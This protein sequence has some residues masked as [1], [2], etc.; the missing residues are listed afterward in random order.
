MKKKNEN[1]M[2]LTQNQLLLWTGQQLNPD[3]P[4]YNM[5]MTY[6]IESAIS[7]PHFKLAFQK[8]VDKSDVLRSVFELEGEE[9]VQKYLPAIAYEL[10]IIDFS[11]ENNPRATFSDWSQ[12]RAKHQFD[13]SQCLF[14][15]VLIK[16]AENHYIWYLNQHHL[17]T[18]GW[19][20]SIIFSKVSDFYTRAIQE[21][22]TVV[23]EFPSYQK[24]ITYTQ[25]TKKS[26]KGKEIS[27][28]WEEK[29]KEFPQNQITPYHK[30]DIVL[31]TASERLLIKLGKERSE[32]IR[33]LANIKGIRTWTIDLTLYNIFLTVLYA[34]IYRITGQ[35]SIVIGSP[36]HNRTSK[37]FKDTI[38]FFVETF[39]LLVGIEEEESFISL[40][41][42]VQIESNSFIKNAQAGASTPE[43]NRCFNVFFNYINATN[44]NFNGTPVVTNWVHPGHHD[45]RHHIRL[46]VHDFDTTGEIQL[47]FDL[48][49][50]IFDAQKQEETTEHFL[51][52]LDAFIKNKD[53]NL[54]NVNLITESETLRIKQ[55][56]N[57]ITPYPKD[58]TLLSKFKTQVK[59]TPDEIALVFE[60]KTLTYKEFDQKSNQV[61]NFLLEREIK[62]NDI[63]AISIDR[64]LEMMIYIY[65]IIK[66]GA[67]YLPID[68]SIP[69]ERLSFILR[70]S[71]TKILF[72]DHNN[73]SKDLL[74]ITD[75]FKIAAINNKILSLNSNTPEVAITPD[76]LA[77]II[78][79]SGSTGEPKGVKC[80]HRGIC[81]RLNWM[82]EDY[83]ITKNDTLIQK[84]PIT[85]DVSL[86]ELFWPFQIGAKLIIESPNGH[87]DPEKLIQTIQDNKVTIIH[88]VPSMLNIFLET[89]N[90]KDCISLQRIFCSGEA[91]SAS[92]VARAFEQLNIELHNLYGPTEASVEVTSWHCKKDELS[93]SIPIGNP[94]ANTHIYILDKNLNP[95]PIGTPGELYIGGVQ[96]ANGYLNREN[97]SK[98]HFLKDPFS[99][100][101][102]GM[103]YKTGDLAR[104]RDD[105]AIQYVG[106]IDNQVKVRGLRIELGEIEKVIEKYT[107]ISQAIVIVD[108]Q[109]NLIA[110]YTGEKLNEDDIINVLENKLPLYMVPSYFMYLTHFELLSSGK[111]DRK[112]LPKYDIT[113][114][115]GNSNIAAAPET[116]IEEIILEVWKEVLEI[117]KIG[118]HENFI[119]VGGNSLLA[120]SI[121]SRLKSILELD[122]SITDMFNYPTISTYAQHVEHNIEQL[123]NEF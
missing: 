13:I 94:V 3:T 121:T 30:K 62:T 97:L 31:R 53:A 113:A 74:T 65:G 72:Y 78:Y 110:Y 122:I 85:F 98:K 99:E 55:W 37:N 34:Y 42:K 38:G 5:V 84:T 32:K 102:N 16:L 106:R 51:K 69:P 23:E 107:N 111:V 45:P 64:S 66:S 9:P 17:I 11:N 35:K 26:P 95:L 19:S 46:H 25:E 71:N 92:S 70:D 87:K 52:L 36:T 93:A 89:Q 44:T 109:E 4:L 82:N 117:K 18:D 96:V 83:P 29:Q 49:T 63:I 76:D 73:V 48:N 114:K 91:L 10:I 54:K 90:I 22:L 108:E 15:C 33:E 81:N 104:Y 118:I 59:Q 119:R 27:N 77:Y 8:L 43:M 12:Q 60:G 39:P 7:I 67:T 115:I 56:N 116:E 80:H 47:Y 112:K 1:R 75:G 2:S 14:D 61:A 40:L 68:T 120:I 41:K 58:E 28:H 100:N 57:T 103:M 24:F 105:G 20:T 101:P 86:L 88:F 123:L 79:T 50:H 6:E 21:D